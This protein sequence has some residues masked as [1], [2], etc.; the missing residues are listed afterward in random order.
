MRTR[1]DAAP[2]MVATKGDITSEVAVSAV[3]NA[4][5]TVESVRFVASTTRP[6]R[7]TSDS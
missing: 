3:R 6:A 7:C 2:N 4:T 5:T 1:P